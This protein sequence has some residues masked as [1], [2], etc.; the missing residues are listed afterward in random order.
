MARSV[1][2]GFDTFLSWLVPLQSER[3]AASKHRGTVESSLRN[4]LEVRLFRESGSF[5]HGTGVRAH[6]DVDLLVSLATKPVSSDTALRWVKE[7]LAASFPA[8]VVQIRRPAVV[9]QFNGGRE[10]WE[11]IPGFRN[12][13]TDALPVY[14]IP[15]VPSGWLDSAPT[16]HLAYVTNVNKTPAGGAKK[17]AR[18]MKAWK[19]YNDVP[20]SSFYLEMRASKYMSDETSFVP[21]Y[22]V[23]KLFESLE[24]QGLA[25]MNDPLGLTS[26]FYACSTTPKAEQALSKLATAATRARK[27]LDSFSNEDFNTSFHY[28]GLLFGG[29]FPAR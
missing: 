29:R 27:A 25:A 23:C 22:D 28:L 20:I 3:D 18:L 11:I 26:R 21:I 24:R 16:A 10:A 7:A 12:G 19:Y 5:N 6:C 4:R 8:T 2:E 13:G 1:Q 9:V 17:L 14:E 15:G